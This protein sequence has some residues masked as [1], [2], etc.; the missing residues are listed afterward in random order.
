MEIV[1]RDLKGIKVLDLKGKVT[2]GESE[3]AL[4]D[5][6]L[7]LHEDG[8]NRLIINLAGVP[9]IDSSGL[10][11][12]VR[13]FTSIRKSGGR[14]GLTNLNQRLMDVLRITK[15]VDIFET[16]DSDSEAAKAFDSVN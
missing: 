7:D 16:Y 6:I 12:L 4:R 2:K 1:E 9:Y 11:E 10:G 3:A 8:H 15:L 5:H 14:M 13:C